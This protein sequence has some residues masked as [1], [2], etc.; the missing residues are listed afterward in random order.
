MSYDAD[1]ENIYMVEF[2]S[3]RVIYTSF[4]EVQ[5]V[6]DYCKDEYPTERIKVIYK[7]V[8]VA[9]GEDEE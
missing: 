3:G 9:E 2:E 7:E 6:L 8:Y 5:D 1:F 4:F